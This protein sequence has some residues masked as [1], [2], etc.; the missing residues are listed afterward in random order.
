ML[1]S[2]AGQEHRFEMSINNLHGAFLSFIA[3]FHSETDGVNS[4]KHELLHRRTETHTD[5]RRCTQTN[6]DA[7]R[8]TQTNA[9]THRRTQSK[10]RLVCGQMQSQDASRR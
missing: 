5:T 3:V 6:V 9:D 1:T 2:L 10:Q 7:R 8:R 4:H